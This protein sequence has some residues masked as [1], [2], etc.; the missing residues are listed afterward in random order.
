MRSRVGRASIWLLAV[1]AIP[2]LVQITGLARIIATRLHYPMDLEWMEG[3]LLI[4]AERLLAGQ[5]IYT[6]P[7]SGFMPY[8]YPPL[9]FVLVALA[10]TV[11]GLDYAVGRWISTLAIAAAA[12]LLAR[13]VFERFRPL[14]LPLLWAVLALGMIAAGYPVTTGWY[15]IIRSDSLALAWCVG[16]AAVVERV[17]VGPATSSAGS[18]WRI[19][20]LSA[21]LTAALFTKQ[22][23]IFYVAW[24]LAFLFW[25]ARRAAL[26]LTLTT[27]ALCGTVLL[28]LLLSSSGNYWH[29]TMVV[30]R[31]QATVPARMQSGLTR[32]LEFA[33]Y[34]AALPLVAPLLAL[35]RRLSSSAV[36]WLGMLLAS[37]PAGLLPYAK[38]GGWDNNF[39]GAVVLAGPALLCVLADTLRALQERPRVSRAV[40]WA[41]APALALYVHAR[42]YDYAG[43]M[44]HPAHRSG[45]E[46]LNQYVRNLWGGVLIPHRPWLA[47]RNGHRTEQLHGVSWNDAVMAGLD[48]DFEPFL[49][50]TNPRYILLDGTENPLLMESIRKRYVFKED[51]PA[52]TFSAYTL[53][54]PRLTQLFERRERAEQTAAQPAR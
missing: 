28:A 40:L 47:V 38:P 53:L 54:G 52:R 10:G 27:S 3:G 48:F 31:E 5:T 46:A 2:P 8:V 34:L 50:D 41:A 45:A 35:R 20:G 39:L 4:H 6:D 19:L 32:L 24:L 14:P 13:A 33:P 29:Y 21:L 18:R 42:T 15:D 9:Y 26:T 16:A 22:T 49:R 1:C 43:Y 30:M 11:F 17:A 7:G 36:L 44:M 25:R 12:A 37:L 23:C 51:L